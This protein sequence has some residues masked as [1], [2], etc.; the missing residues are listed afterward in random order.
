MQ[1]LPQTSDDLRNEA[2]VITQAADRCARS[3]VAAMD[4]VRS[5]HARARAIEHAADPFL[6]Y[7]KRLK[8]KFPDATPDTIIVGGPYNLTYAHFD[9]LAAALALP[10]TEGK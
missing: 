9:A 8:E 1:S 7:L 3:M 2:V 5:A 4:A 6:Y 10:S